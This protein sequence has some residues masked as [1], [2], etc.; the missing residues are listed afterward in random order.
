LRGFDSRRL[1]NPRKSRVSGRIPIGHVWPSFRSAVGDSGSLQTLRPPAVHRG[2]P[3]HPTLAMR[4]NNARE[5]SC[6]ASKLQQESWGR[7]RGKTSAA[8]TDPYPSNPRNTQRGTAGTSVCAC[9]VASKGGECGDLPRCSPFLNLPEPRV[10]AP[11]RWVSKDEC[12]GAS[13]CSNPQQPEPGDPVSL[14]GQLRR[15]QCPQ[16]PPGPS[17]Q[18]VRL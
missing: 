11:S 3:R 10:S 13:P 17:F 12:N 9:E 7:A 15:P 5:P 4:P 6:G 1:H 16:R 18:T 2:R 14:L 8:S